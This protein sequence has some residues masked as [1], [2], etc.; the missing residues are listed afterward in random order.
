MMWRYSGELKTTS[1]EWRRLLL[2]LGCVALTLLAGCSRTS[3]STASL[4]IR[5]EITPQPLKAGPAMVALDIAGS[6]GAPV[7][8]AHITLEADMSHP[9]MAPAFADTK[10]VS[11][12]RYQGNINFSMGGDWVVLVHIRL[13]DGQKIEREVPVTGIRAN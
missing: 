9:G 5:S 7:T 11:P 4:T 3:G 8:G 6:K 1:P 2:G 12:G 13:A 10:E